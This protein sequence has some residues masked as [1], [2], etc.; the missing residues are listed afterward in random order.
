MASTDPTG[1]ISIPPELTRGVS[2]KQ[3]V[4]VA[5]T[6][7]GTLATAFANGQTVDGVT[8]ATNDRILLKDQTAGSANGIYKVNASGAPT[9]AFD[10]DQDLTTAVP[11]QEVLGAIV[12]V[13]DGTVNGGTSWRA[14]NTTAPTLG[15]TTIT[16][17]AYAATGTVTSVALTVPAEFSVSGSPVTS[18]GTLAITKANETA[19]TVWA[20]PTSGAAA[21]PAFRALVAADSPAG[22]GALH[23]ILITNTPVGSPLIFADLIQNEAQTDLVYAD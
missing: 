20:G 9:R 16:W 14:T 2:W 18:S 5:T 13:I 17:A 3:P 8:L 6:A 10:M 21:T 19:N 11:A 7:N 23:E 4:R 12:Y 15:T 22:V 1:Y